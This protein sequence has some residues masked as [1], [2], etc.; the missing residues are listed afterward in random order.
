MARLIGYGAYNL[1]FDR[2]LG[3]S[4]G[5]N[6]FQF[7]H[8]GGW[9]VNLVKVICYRKA[10]QEGLP[11]V[12]NPRTIPVYTSAGVVNPAFLANLANLVSQARDKQFTVQLCIFS[13]H[14][15]ARA[16]APEF[17]PEVLKQRAG[18]D[19]CSY[20]RYFFNPDPNGAVLIEQKKL[21]RAIVGHLK[22]TGNLSNVIWEIANEMRVDLCT[23]VNNL[24][25]N[26]SLTAWFNAIAQTIRTE[27]GA[28]APVIFTSTGQY[29]DVPRDVPDGGANEAV[30]FQ[31]TRPVG[32]CN[33][34]AFVPSLFD[35]HSDQW[36]YNANYGNALYSVIRQRFAGYGY[37][38]P[39]FI[40]NTDGMNDAERTPAAIEAWATMAFRAGHSFST[41]QTYPPLPFDIPVLDALKRAHFAPPIWQT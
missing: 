26:C 2:D 38:N 17:L 1:C 27:I 40:I 7:L 22:A 39:T 10:S 41:K 21:V 5:K 11:P 28:G 13:Y 15:V 30:T 36:D 31:K 6:F 34:P 9:P 8:D 24:A 4:Q 18:T 37:T 33:T 35:L 32:D 19:K 16:E 29:T 14:S 20:L 23:R 12:P 3:A 25:A